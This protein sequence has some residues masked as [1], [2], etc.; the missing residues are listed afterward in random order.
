M[1]SSYSAPLV[2]HDDEPRSTISAIWPN[3]MH[4]QK[5]VTQPEAAV[6]ESGLDSMDDERNQPAANRTG[7]RRKKGGRERLQLLQ[8]SKQSQSP[9]DQAAMGAFA[10]T[11]KAAV[12]PPG[13]G[14]W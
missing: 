14:A 1:M 6:I 10:C 2:P 11:A 3:V 12:A 4:G 9:V 8:S 13:G 7:A 5:H